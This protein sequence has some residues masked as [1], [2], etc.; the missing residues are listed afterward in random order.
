MFRPTCASATANRLRRPVRQHSRAR[1]IV[2]R[3][4]RHWICGAVATDIGTL[5]DVRTRHRATQLIHP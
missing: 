1:K 5:A 4:A 3:V 2:N